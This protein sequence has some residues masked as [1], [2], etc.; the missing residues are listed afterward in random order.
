MAN[1]RAF[2]GTVALGGI[3]ALLVLLGQQE[4]VEEASGLWSTADEP[5]PLAFV[6]LDHDGLARHDHVTL[7]I[8]IDD[9]Q[10]VIPGSIG[11]NSGVCNQNGGNMHAVHTH[12]DGGLL[13]IELNDAGD[14]PL[15]VFFDIWGVHFDETGVFDHRANETHEMSMY[16]FNSDEQASE[17]NRVNSFDDY[18]L[19]NGETIEVHY[20]AR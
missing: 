16:V 7:K 15:G 11:I 19:L 12:N 18:L 20:K 3:I 6:C 4:S 10:Q 17:E 13:H 1:E 9:E 8:F 5:D 14:V 2:W